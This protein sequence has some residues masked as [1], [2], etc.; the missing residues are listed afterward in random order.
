MDNPA[1]L[2]IQLQ[3]SNLRPI[4]FRVLSK[5]HGLN[6]KLDA[7]ERLAEYIG[8]K[9]G[10]EWRGAKAQE[11]LESVAKCWKEQDRGIFVDGEGV[12]VVIKEV[13]DRGRT[14]TQEKNS[15]VSLADLKAARLDTVVDD[16]DTIVDGGVPPKNLSD[17]HDWAD[18]FKVIDA[19]EQPIFR[20][21]HLRKSYDFVPQMANA[22][23]LKSLNVK[24]GIH[25]FPNRLY[26]VKDRLARNQT[27]QAPTFTSLTSVTGAGIKA[28]HTISSIKN[29][30]GRHGQRFLLMGLLTR[31]ANGN[32]SLQDH[33][34]AIELDIS[35]ALPSEGSYFAPG[36]IL[37]ADGIYSNTG[38]FHVST[39]GHPPAEKREITLDH[40]GNID[41][42]GIHNIL[43]SAT[44][45]IDKPLKKR[46][47]LLER[48]LYNHTMLFLGGDCHLDNLRVMDGLK[49][50]FAKLT[51]V[52]HDDGEEK[53]PIAIV[54]NGPFVSAPLHAT[55]SSSTNSSSSATYKAYFDALA[56]LL[57]GFPLIT[58]HCSL[59][60]VPGDNDPWSSSF[61]NGAAALWPQAKIPKIFGTRLTRVAKTCVWTSNPSH[62]NY[63]SQEIVLC[64]Q[65][66]GAKF[67]RNSVMFPST[68]Q[69]VEDEDSPIGT[70]T[71]VDAVTLSID[72]LL[73]PVETVPADV[74][75]ARKLVRTILDQGHLSPFPLHLRGV[76]WEYDHI[77]QLSPLPSVLVLCDVSS[78]KFDVTYEGCHVLNPGTLI[79]RN[80]LTYVL[81]TPST[82][83]ASFEELYF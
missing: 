7:L 3:A 28:S 50:L 66:I 69:A 72:A 8:P 55:Y 36:A 29:L 40:Y 54:F 21:N 70:Q 76:N 19:F 64:R 11:F 53:L 30:L 4:A 48:E 44:S 32:W 75:E 38:T 33:S 9:F 49:K 81:Y 58:Q 1:I 17:L 34:D 16:P 37:L 13:A 74:K 24:S 83:K 47:Q 27:F 10:A 65:D 18:Y 43:P 67:R 42:L 73:K 26:I 63:L 51:A 45:K 59:V 60:F 52:A 31:N 15:K 12:S 80:K 77:L 79:H 25:L 39:I 62:V 14:K 2:P 46:L 56:E 71:S 20:Y 22:F 35:Q 23:K 68:L 41:Y 57:E 6:I 82:R 78:P 61:S 5:K